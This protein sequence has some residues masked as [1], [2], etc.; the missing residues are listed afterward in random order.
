MEEETKETTEKEQKSSTALN[1]LAGQS[2]PYLLQHA[3][4]PVDWYPWGE[5]AF[6]KAIVEDKPVFLSIG[7]ST[8][9][10]CHV[11]EK[12]SFE[13]E[14]VAA[15]MNDTFICIK[16]DREER[17]DIDE[18]Y[19]KTAQVMGEQG[20][21]PLTILM[22]PQK[23]PFMVK[24]YIPK[25]SNYYRVGMLDLVPGIQEIWKDDVQRE[26]IK[27][28]SSLLMESLEKS[29][30]KKN[31]YHKNYEL[32]DEGETEWTMDQIIQ[33]TYT[34]LFNDY[35]EI[36][37]GFGQ[38]PMFPTPH[39][40]FFLLRYWKGYQDQKALQM[41]ENTLISMRKGGIYDQI[42]HGF[43][44]YS[45]DS[46]W[47]IPHFEKMLYDQPLLSIAYIETYL[48]TGKQVYATIARENL[49]FSLENMRST[50]GGFYSAKDA[51]SEG[52]EGKFYLWK[53]EQLQ[54]ILTEEEL[55]TF[56]EH[57]QLEPFQE[58]FL[59][60]HVHD[61]GI[62]LVRPEICPEML[63]NN[64]NNNTD[65]GDK[66]Q[67]ESTYTD[68]YPCS[69]THPDL[70][71]I[72]AKLYRAR[73]E[74]VPPFRDEKILTD[75]NAMMIWALALAGRTFNDNLYTTAAK[76]CAEFVFSNLC[77][78]NGALL[79]CHHKNSSNIAAFL[80]DHAYMVRACI[81]L[82]ETTF[83]AKY[84]K[85]AIRFN[86]FLTDH[87]YDK[88]EG[89]FFFISE[90]NTEFKD[91]PKKITDG[92]IPS[93]NS[94]CAMNLIKLE[95][96]TGDI[97]YRKLAEV[98][99]RSILS[100]L[101]QIPVACTFLISAL[102]TYREPCL[103]I[104][105]AGLAENK[106]TQEM[107]QLLHRNFLPEMNLVLKTDND[108]ELEELVPYSKDMERINGVATAYLCKDKQCYPPITDVAS[109]EE[110]INRE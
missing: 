109:I 62:I 90:L 108:P 10:W 105:I 80:D 106:D 8:C 5:E 103:D 25:K 81:E 47:A 46:R 95:H 34:M 20:G 2:S 37:G 7:Y 110:L 48:A 68:A 101:S 38:A 42:G 51:D 92:A 45:T 87:F 98:T 57:Y 17:P 60:E 78:Q 59:N 84:L 50:E 89:A 33:K 96:L 102:E 19:M 100:E 22:T 69:Y 76:E 43:H 75:W 49:S 29:S 64:N 40:L 77:D 41:V 79:H 83:E 23:E 58:P 14:E 99:L 70:K 71:N 91:R 53:P 104:V 52:V 1:H 24:T 31:D 35:N 36:K 54:K 9:H 93:G 18:I 66:I 107:L 30:G 6:Y 72:I 67:N 88:E 63:H 73:E 4:N 74:R 12:E 27:Q 15:L 13:D 61:S 32:M 21:W 16:V 44:R 94:I 85:K 11:M 3:S 82:Y 56:L 39:H 86:D 26:H 55:D 28:Q 97:H 65:P